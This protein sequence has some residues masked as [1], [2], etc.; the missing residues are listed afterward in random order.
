MVDRKDD[1]RGAV[2]LL[3]I[4]GHCCSYM[5][6]SQRDVGRKGPDRLQDGSFTGAVSMQAYRKSIVR[7]PEWNTICSISRTANSVL[8]QR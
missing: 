7:L 5:P 6:L 3:Y 4:A 8:A 2:I 1:E